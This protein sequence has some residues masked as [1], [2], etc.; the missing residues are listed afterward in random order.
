MNNTQETAV[1]KKKSAAVSFLCKLKEGINMQNR[2]LFLDF[3]GIYSKEEIEKIPQTA[4]LDLTDISG[5]DMYC[6]PEAEAELKKRLAPFGVS[7]IH[8][9]DSGNYHYMTKYFAE[10]IKI[11]FSLVMF[12]FHNDMQIPMIHDLTSC[13]G[14]ARDVLMEMDNLC[15]LIII[16]PDQKTLN[17]IDVKKREKLVCI[18]LQELEK[19]HA[20]EKIREIKMDI[21]FYISI[22]KDVLDKTYAVT[23]WNQGK[24]S[25]TT[26]ETLLHLFLVKGEVIGVDICGE[27]SAAGGSIPEYAQAERVNSKTDRELYYYIKKYIHFQKD[28]V[29]LQ[30]ENKK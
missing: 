3:T 7:G 25:L 16:G 28:S 19:K 22:D 11:P 12:D 4:H 1:R 26:L 14:W 17:E 29:F 9:L 27:Y 2:N 5:T 20:G 24:M 21:P 8:F 6:T 10:K 13:G 18:S 15:Q 30:N 23:N